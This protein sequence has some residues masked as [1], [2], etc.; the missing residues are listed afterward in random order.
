M[1]QRRGEKPAR[2]QFVVYGDQASDGRAGRVVIKVDKRRERSYAVP[3]AS[4]GSLSADD[5]ETI[6]LSKNL[7]RGKHKVRVI[8]VPDDPTA[9]DRSKSQLMVVKVKRATSGRGR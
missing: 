7:R 4:A 2:V 9:Y 5:V 8:L 3:V 6:R 1:T